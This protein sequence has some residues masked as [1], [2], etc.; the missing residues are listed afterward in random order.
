[1]KY[2]L[3]QKMRDTLDFI[4]KHMKE[5][6]GVSPSISEICSGT[7]IKSR[8]NVHA[9]LRRLEERGYIKTLSK[10]SRSITV[11]KDS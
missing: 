4:I 3:T 7:G 1:M 5:S 9:N 8:G 6:D 11:T 10:R 2:G